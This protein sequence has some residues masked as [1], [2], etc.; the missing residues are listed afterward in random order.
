MWKIYMR[1]DTNNNLCH[2]THFTKQHNCFYWVNCRR[3]I[4]ISVEISVGNL[5]KEL[6]GIYEYIIWKAAKLIHS[7]KR[8]NIRMHFLLLFILYIDDGREGVAV[9][10]N[11]KSKIIAS[12]IMIAHFNLQIADCP[13]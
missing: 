10:F 6:N 1:E 7:S 3:W 9:P 12:K 11:E 4:S 8:A 5:G 2:T 13:F